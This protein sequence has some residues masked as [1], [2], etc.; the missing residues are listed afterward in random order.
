MSLKPGALIKGRYEI[1]A[2]LGEGGFAR[3]YRARDVDLDRVVA[4]KVLKMGTGNAAPDL[5]RFQREAKLLGQLQHQNIVSVF[6]IDLLEDGSPAIVMEY[7]S[8]KSLQQLLLEND[9][10][11][12]PAIKEIFSQICDGLNFAHE[13]GVVH[14]DLS[15]A[16]IFL[17]DGDTKQI[18]II[19]FGLARLVSDGETG[20]LTL[21]Q[22]GALVGNPAYMSPEQSRGEK[23]DG[24]S[25]IYSLACLLYQCMSGKP[26][27]EAWNPIGLLHLHQMEYPEIPVTDWIDKLA[28]Q[29]YQNIVLKCMQKDRDKRFQKAQ[30]LKEALLDTGTSTQ[31][32]GLDGWSSN[33]S[34][35][36]SRYSRRTIGAL[37][38]CILFCVLVAIF[39]KDWAVAALK[40][41]NADSVAGLKQWVAA[42]LTNSS[43]KQAAELYAGLLEN[44]SIRA[45]KARSANVSIELAE[46]YKRSGNLAAHAELLQTALDSG[47]FD[48]AGLKKFQSLLDNAYASS[49][50]SLKELQLRCLLLEKIIGSGA[51]KAFVR[52]VFDAV[53]VRGLPISMSTFGRDATGEESR[54]MEMEVSAILDTMKKYHWSIDDKEDD[55]LFRLECNSRSTQEQARKRAEL[56][57]LHLKRTVSANS[58]SGLRVEII[59]NLGNVDLHIAYEQ[60][61]KYLA[62]PEKMS[63]VHRIQL[64][65]NTAEIAKNLGLA[66]EVRVYCNQAEDILEKEI[67]LSPFDG[68]YWATQVYNTQKT[69]LTPAEIEQRKITEK[70]KAL[71]PEADK[72]LAPS[73]VI[74]LDKSSE[75]ITSGGSHM[76]DGRSHAIFQAAASILIDL[77]DFKTAN[78]YLKKYLELLKESGAKPER[79]KLFQERLES[80]KTAES[81]RKLLQEIMAKCD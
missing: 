11:G 63:A 50:P 55:L 53:L 33:L 59:D 12:L 71:L 23:L 43:P 80:P 9:S 65:M 34:K 2:E 79:S 1:M 70:L 5:E 16:N 10:L 44:E 39:G 52:P 21:T 4:L 20:G 30:E 36:K 54:V 3:V 17:L 76:E 69:L 19:D 42:Q 58:A 45:D 28:E 6:S 47:S 29:H 18:K 27:F 24:R 48:E 60:A 32:A 77:R 67:M 57:L 56:C 35:P 74:M 49:A 62:E 26:P 40:S 51:K 78:E 41:S 22:T 73:A 68:M 37:A 64:V 25:D 14:R 31:V 72:L 46:C 15:A 8:G 13:L 61:K 7:L 66:R 75:R 81:T 38:A